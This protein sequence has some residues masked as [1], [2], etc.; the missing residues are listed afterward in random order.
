[1]DKKN[2]LPAIMGEVKS[3]EE[4][5][6]EIKRDSD[7]YLKFRRLDEE[8]REKLIEF[9]M[10]VRGVKMTYDSFFKHI[11]DFYSVEFA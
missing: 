9:C 2:N 4:V 1:M 7:T 5:L 8:F 11:L 3:R 6:D 10:G